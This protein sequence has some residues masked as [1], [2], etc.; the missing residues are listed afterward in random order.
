MSTPSKPPVVAA[1]PV[2]DEMSH[3]PD[4]GRDAEFPTDKLPPFDWSKVEYDRWIERR[5]PRCST[6]GGTLGHDRPFSSNCSC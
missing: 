3:G 1:M 2:T 4:R 5:G 6:C